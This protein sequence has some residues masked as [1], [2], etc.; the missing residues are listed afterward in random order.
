[1]KRKTNRLLAILVAITLV[2]SVFAAPISAL[3]GYASKNMMG[4]YSYTKYNC[5]FWFQNNFWDGW[6]GVDGT[7]R[8]AW[9]GLSPLNADSIVHRDILSCTGIGSMGIGLS[10]GGPNLSTSISGHT[11][12]FSYTVEDTWYINTNY[13]YIITG[14]LAAWNHSVRTSATVQFGSTFYTWSN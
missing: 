11:A 6:W 4:S 9:L 13:G 7:S 10:P 3:S 1:M 5:S 14:M 8:T 12:T 2:I